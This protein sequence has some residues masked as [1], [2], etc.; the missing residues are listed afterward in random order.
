VGV[1]QGARRKQGGGIS[2]S[3][4]WKTAIRPRTPDARRQLQFGWGL[5]V[6]NTNST[7][8]A[9]GSKHAHVCTPYRNNGGSSHTLHSTCIYI[10]T[11]VSGIHSALRHRC[12]EWN[13]DSGPLCCK[14]PSLWPCLQ[15][16][17]GHVYSKSMS[18][19]TAHIERKDT[20]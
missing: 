6:P 14:R 16:V 20:V 8:T 10:H 18:V 15:Q 2:M 3:R 12:R 1:S 7:L 17:S 9:N 19:A 5:R 13:R 11:V 4:E